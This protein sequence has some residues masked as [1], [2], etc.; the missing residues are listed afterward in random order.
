MLGL[1]SERAE[2]VALSRKD[3]SPER[4]RLLAQ[5][6]AETKNLVEGL[7][8]DLSALWVKVYPEF[9]LPNWEKEGYVGKLRIGGRLLAEQGSLAIE[10]SAKHPSDTVRGW[11][12]FAWSSLPNLPF[13]QRLTLFRSLAAD[14]HF[15]VRE[16]AW[17]ALR[18]H[19]ESELHAA[20]DHL[21][22]WAKEPDANLR[23]FASEIT[24]PRGV[25]CRHIQQLK[26]NPDLGLPILEPLKSDPAEYVRLSVANWLND[27]GKSQPQWLSDLTERWLVESPT[28]E[29]R[30]IVKRG[31]RS[32]SKAPG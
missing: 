13:E 5:G 6:E 25:W 20:V 29:T 22:D 9:P 18:P 3:V 24:R 1:F 12:C 23:R 10:N 15:G 8:F 16:W 11:A 7:A 17:L 32:S 28:D 19:I 30:A 4:L 26:D 14:S 27:A 2:A 31:L 21:S